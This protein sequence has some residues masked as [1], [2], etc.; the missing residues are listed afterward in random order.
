LGFDGLENREERKGLGDEWTLHVQDIG[1]L[2][3]SLAGS[4]VGGF[5]ADNLI[6]LTST[7]NRENNSKWAMARCPAAVL[8]PTS[9]GR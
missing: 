9:P 3:A 2:S 5:V 1:E 7:D 6:P 8:I 4:V